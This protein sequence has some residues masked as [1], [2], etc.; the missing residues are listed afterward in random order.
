MALL[1]QTDVVEKHY[2]IAYI[3]SPEPNTPDAGVTSI[4]GDSKK[5]ADQHYHKVN[6]VAATPAVTDDQ[7]NVVQEEIPGYFVCAENTQGG[8]PHTHAV[9]E[10]VLEDREPVW[11]QNEESEDV[12]EIR[13]LYEEGLKQDGEYLKNAEEDENFYMGDQWDTKDLQKLK[14]KKRACLTLNEIESKIDTLS[15]YYRQ[16]RY[17]ITFFPTENGDQLVADVL[18]NLAKHVQEKNNFDYREVEVFEDKAITGRGN[19]KIWI[20]YNKDIRGEIKLRDFPYDKVVYGEH[21]DK[22]CDDLEY[23]VAWEWVSKNKLKQLYPDKAKAIDDWMEATRLKSGT[24]TSDIPE[25]FTD[26]YAAESKYDTKDGW[27]N[28]GTS[29]RYVDPSQKKY[30]LLE[31][32]KKVY[33]KVRIIANLR[34]NYIEDEYFY[35]DLPQESREKLGTIP[36]LTMIPRV[37]ESIAIMQSAGAILLSKDESDLGDAWS[38]IPDYAKKRG[39]NVWGKVRVM[40]D[41]Q[42]MINKI[43]SNSVDIIARMAVYGWMYDSQTFNGSDRAKQKFITQSST[44]G[45]VLEVGS[46]SAP[47]LKFEGGKYPNELV[48]TQ[49]FIS[50]KMNEVSNINP[51]LLGQS[52]Q[53]QQ[54]GTNF[55]AK[56]EGALVGNE[57]LFDNSSLSK[58]MLGRALLAAIKVVFGADPERVVKLLK[59]RIARGQQVVVGDSVQD[60]DK[61]PIEDIMER[62]NNDDYSNYDVVVGEAQHSPTRRQATWNYML[63]LAQAG[64]AI[65]PDIFY[66]LSE[67][68]LYLKKQIQAYNANVAST[69]KQQMDSKQSTEIWKTIIANLPDD[70]K[71][72]PQVLAA[73]GQQAL[74]GDAG[75]QGAKNPQ[76]QVKQQE[77]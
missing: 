23:N 72:D 24:D 52:S 50:R 38:I 15:G 11:L 56:R 10:L 51:E 48:Q 70:M 67:L 34:D 73:M 75:Q 69:E 2:H 65:P 1:K 21:R 14:S 3:L 60:Q 39:S 55:I 4:D 54:S 28:F 18:S 30:K 13:Q 43:H 5:Q 32:H 44:P 17:D 19:Y 36:G 61:F 64:L 22:D 77:Q 33:D 41:H 76:P 9:E 47:P 49:E 58:R 20:D 71:Q 40:K 27:I 63:Q 26:K 6:Y 29:E 68:P 62:L 25:D 45:F 42:K 7:G 37:I 35:E 12:K 46:V 66:E 59:N 16:N 31:L 53:S 8:T 57:F 74:N